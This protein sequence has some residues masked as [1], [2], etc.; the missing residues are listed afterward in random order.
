MYTNGMTQERKAR[1]G[2]RRPI[3]DPER[4]GAL[5]AWWRAHGRLPAFRELAALFGWK[6]PNAATRFYRAAE[7]AGYLERRGRRLFPAPLLSGVKYYESISA[8]FPSPAEDELCDIITLDEYLL[9]RSDSTFLVRVSGDSMTGAGI[10]PGDVV[11][12]ERGA[13]ARSGDIV[14]AQVDGEWTLKHYEKSKR[15]EIVLRAAN[16]KYPEIRPAREL[17]VGGVVRGSFRRYLKPASG[18]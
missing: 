5:R 9:G 11:I 13:V 18:G 1:R 14:V 10:L 6:S 16:P 7:N 12:V 17:V 4:L 2:G 15:G 3:L 8:G